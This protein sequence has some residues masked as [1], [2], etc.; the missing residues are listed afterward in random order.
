LAITSIGSFGTFSKRD[1]ELKPGKY[2][3]IGTRNGYRDV[4][5]EV[6]V[7]PGQENLTISVSCSEPI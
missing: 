3:V 1:I 6:T 4:R 2:I 7:A 5:R